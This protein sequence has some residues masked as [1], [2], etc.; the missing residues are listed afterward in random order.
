MHSDHNYYLNEAE[1]IFQTWDEK[2]LGKKIT[3]NDAS[4]CAHWTLRV[5]DKMAEIFS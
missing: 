4:A 3:C 2:N 1:N 5:I